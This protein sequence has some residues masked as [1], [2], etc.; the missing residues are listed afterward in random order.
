MANILKQFDSVGGFSIDKE[1]IIDKNKN[2]QNI[3]TLELQ[4]SF[5]QDS[6][7]KSYIMQ[8]INT[9]LMTIDDINNQIPL[10]SGTINFINSHIVAS[11]DSGGG[12]YVLKIESAVTC[13]SSGSTSVLSSMRTIIKDSIPIGETWTINESPG[14]NRYTFSTVR[15]G[16]PATIKWVACVEVTSVYW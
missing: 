8:G 11:N 15:S 10:A 1:L 6:S 7:K 3:N 9:T 5:F 16:T 12:V 2:L 4:N 14:A 13:G